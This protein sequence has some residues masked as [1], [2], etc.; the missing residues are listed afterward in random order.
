MQV[1]KT[2]FKIL[3]KQKHQF[4][5]YISIFAVL[6]GVLTSVG[7]EE[8]KEF[9]ESRM[10]IVIFDYDNSEKSRYLMEYMYSIH[11]K[12][13]IDDDKEVIQDNLYWQEID[14]VLYINEGYSE[15]GKVSNIKRDGTKVGAY[16]DGQIAS[17][18]KAFDTYVAAGYSLEEANAKA[19]ESLDNAGL[20]TYKGK[21]T[22]TRPKLY[23]YYTY[24]TYIMIMLL[25]NV[26]APIIMVYNKKEI[27]DRNMIAPMTAKSRNLQL[28]GASAVLS[29]AVW[30][31]LIIVSAIM[32]KGQ[33]FNGA[34]A[35]NMVSSFVFLILTVG[36]VSLVSNF[37]L[38]APTIS[39]ISNI[40]ALGMA[41]L[42]G[43]FVPLEIFSDNVLKLS[44]LMPTYW[45]VIATES[46]YKDGALDTFWKCVGIEAL[47]AVAFV[48]M[49]L[50]VAKVVKERR[51]A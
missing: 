35:L 28:I 21:T 23:Y 43:V 31:A 5:I 39:M 34:N 37:N 38:K 18:Q 49:A 9:K 8:R 25:M 24:I 26:M 27:R 4:V 15:T 14:Y 44:K 7:G 50:V 29:I 3:D 17:Y 47:Y 11:N 6:L 46:L 48:A 30:A 12:V 19:I 13:D 20:V 32:F 45:H 22:V 16:A 40:I 51:E 42:G 10:D 36:L 41:F 1:F 33:I 2:F